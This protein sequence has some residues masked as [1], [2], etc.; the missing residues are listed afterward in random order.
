MPRRATLSAAVV[1]V[2]AEDLHLVIGDRGAERFRD[3]DRRR[4][5]LLAGRAPR[6][7]D[8][9][10]LAGLLALDDLGDERAPERAPDLVV[11]EERGH[12]DE[13]RRDQS[14]ELLGVALEQAAIVA[15]P[16]GIFARSSC[17]RCAG[18]ASRACSR[19]SRSSAF[20]ESCRGRWRARNRSS[21]RS[22]VDGTAKCGPE[23]QSPYE[24]RDPGE[25]NHVVDGAGRDRRV[26]HSA[27]LGGVW[28][29]RDRDA[30]VFVDGASPGRAIGA[31]AG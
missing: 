8:P 4:V 7:P 26:G 1:D 27:E 29:L 21:M 20:R 28:I 12:L 11:A 6:A 14:V 18:G 3:Q 15:A 31:R 22:G 2:R 10:L 16:C 19:E 25:R 9:D 23:R 24:G 13:H 30:S 17:A 5:R